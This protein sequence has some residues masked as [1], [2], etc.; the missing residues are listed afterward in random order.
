MKKIFKNKKENETLEYLIDI[1]VSMIKGLI[2]SVSTMVWLFAGFLLLI[3]LINYYNQDATLIINLLDLNIRIMKN[4]GIFWGV[5][6]IFDSIIY[7][8]ELTNE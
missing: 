8:K 3:S 7:Y 5:I 4:W 1:T 2:S 6:W